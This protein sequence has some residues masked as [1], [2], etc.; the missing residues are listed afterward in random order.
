MNFF[1]SAVLPIYLKEKP[2]SL[3]MANMSN[4]FFL[5]VTCLNFV[6]ILPETVNWV[7]KSLNFLLLYSSQSNHSDYYSSADL[8]IMSP[9]ET[10]CSGKLNYF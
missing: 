7:K 10:P 2:E 1:V 5:M 3:F 4:S 9:P 6:L 8:K